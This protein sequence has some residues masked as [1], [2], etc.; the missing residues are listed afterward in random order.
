MSTYSTVEH[1][2]LQAADRGELT[3]DGSAAYGISCNGTEADHD[4][5]VTVNNLIGD[6]MLDYTIAER[7]GPIVLTAAGVQELQ[8]AVR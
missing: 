1:L 6:G 8:A 3:Y 2:I 5:V 4:V 7:T